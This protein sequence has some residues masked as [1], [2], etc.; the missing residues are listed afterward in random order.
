MKQ[1]LNEEQ[2][3]PPR[4]GPEG[5]EDGLAYEPRSVQVAD[6]KHENVDGPDAQGAAGVEVAEVVRLRARF[7]QN[8][9]D[10]ESGEDEEKIDASPSP[11][12]GLVE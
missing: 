1:I 2:I 7:Q 8:R 9:R 3:C 6:Q 11:E 5:F 4:R 12:R 10:Q